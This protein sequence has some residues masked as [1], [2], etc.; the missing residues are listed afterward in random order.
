MAK[1]TV[2]LDVEGIGR[3][4][5]A[6]PMRAVVNRAARDTAAAARAQTSAEVTVAEYTTDREAASVGVPAAEQAA[7]GVLTR[8]AAAAGLE[9]RPG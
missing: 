8:G 1:W 2:T 5:K 7:R 9:V 3:I 4:L 6:P